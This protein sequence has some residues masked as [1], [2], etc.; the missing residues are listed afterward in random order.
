MLHLYGAVLDSGFSPLLW[1][2]LS[3][4]LASA[5]WP[6]RIDHFMC[7]IFSLIKLVCSNTFLFG[8]LIAIN[9]GG[10]TIIIF[11][12]LLLSYMVILC[13]LRAHISVGRKKALSTGGSHIT[14]VILFFGHCTFLYL[15][16]VSSLPMDKVMA[17]FYTLATPILNPIIYTARNAKVK[18]AMRMLLNRNIISDSK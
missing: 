9:G 14:V 1:T 17:V 6:N 8:L 7:D 2:N 12:T 5:L 10:M 16:P 11:L 3:H 18:T 15:W 13:S 4:I